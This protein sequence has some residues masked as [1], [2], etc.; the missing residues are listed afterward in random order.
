MASVHDLVGSRGWQKILTALD[1]DMELAVIAV[2]DL[3]S[4]IVQAREAQEVLNLKNP[5]DLQ[6]GAHLDDWDWHYQLQ[7]Q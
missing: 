2:R 5:V 1:C 4:P 3:P 7:R 6:Q